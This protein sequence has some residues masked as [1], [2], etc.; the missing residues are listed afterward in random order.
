MQTSSGSQGA[1]ATL[2]ALYPMQS[3]ADD[4]DEA[5]EDEEE[6]LPLVYPLPSD[7]SPAAVTGGLSINGRT[8]VRKAIVFAVD[9]R[10]AEAMN[11]VFNAAGGG[12]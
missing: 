12:H 2:P 11:A 3:S 6:E 9:I 5:D 8:S 1:D 10:H 4:E 7:V